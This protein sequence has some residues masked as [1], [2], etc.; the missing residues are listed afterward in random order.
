[1]LLFAALLLAF[2]NRVRIWVVRRL[3]ESRHAHH[4]RY[5]PV[6]AIGAA[7]IYGGFFTAGMSVIVLALLGATLEDSLTRLNALKQIVAFSVNMAAVVFFLLSGQVIWLLA[8]A[9]AVGAIIG[10]ALGGRVAGCM[11]P[12]A[13]RW[14]V[15]AV[16]VTLAIVYWFR[17]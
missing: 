8:G 16:G 4:G 14:I 10:G 3:A 6:I 13:L 1:M 12:D 2:Q 9:M 15:V 5:A 7:G 11:N 17:N